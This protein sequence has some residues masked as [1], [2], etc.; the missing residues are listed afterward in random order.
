MTMGNTSSRK[1]RSSRKRP[2][3]NFDSQIAIGRDDDAGVGLLFLGAAHGAHGL[4]LKRAEQLG[5]AVDGQFTHFVDEQR[6]AVGVAE[7][8]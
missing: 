4:G 3:P 8:A 6:A 5:L 2:R 7:E 1:K